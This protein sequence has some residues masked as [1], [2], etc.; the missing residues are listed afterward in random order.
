M[1]TRGVRRRDEHREYMQEWYRRPGNAEKARARSK[2]WNAISWAK[3]KALLDTFRADGCRVCG[4]RCSA[5][6]VAHHRDP[7]LKL[8]NIGESI[9]NKVGHARFVAELAKC[10]CL[11]HNCHFKFH[12]GIIEL[13]S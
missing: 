6:L 10:T 13:P 9:R 5:V 12:A 11:C 3:N 2:H 1:E 8:F 4:E 7:K